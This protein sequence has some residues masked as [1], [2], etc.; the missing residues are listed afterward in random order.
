[1]SSA[2]ATPGPVAIVITEIQNDTDQVITV[3]PPTSTVPPGVPIAVPP[4]LMLG[5][6]SIAMPQIP[7]PPPPSPPTPTPPTPA[8]AL[9]LTIGTNITAL[10]YTDGSG[11]T[12]LY[13]PASQNTETL[14]RTSVPAASTL[15]VLIDETPG[16]ITTGGAIEVFTV[17]LD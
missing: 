12:Y 5:P 7:P 6:L 4:H 3:T 8:D 14:D 9:T 15:H 13:S 17:T 2:S 11:K 1:M 10:L 16:D